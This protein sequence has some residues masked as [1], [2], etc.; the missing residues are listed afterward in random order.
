M[1]IHSLRKLIA[2]TITLAV[3]LA[4][5]FSPLLAN[6]AAASSTPS[7]Q[8]S[9]HQ[10]AGPSA[11]NDAMGA[12]WRI[13]TVDS[14]PDVGSYGSIAFDPRDGS[15]WASYYDATN[16]DLKLAHYLRSTGGN[17][18]PALTWQ[19]TTI[20]GSASSDRGQY[21]S[22]DVY[23]NAAAGVWRLGVSYY[24][25]TTKGLRYYEKF[26]TPAPDGSGWTMY[27][28]EGSNNINDVIGRYSSIK[29]DQTGAANVAYQVKLVS[30]GKNGLKYAHFVGAGNGSCWPNNR[31]Q[32]DEI[33]MA[34]MTYPGYYTSIDVSWSG[35]P[36]IAYYD[37]LTRDLKY[38]YLSSYNGSPSGNCGPVKA[39]GYTWT[40]YTIDSAGDVGKSA[41]YHAS[42]NS[43]HDPAQV[44][45]YDATNGQLKYAFQIGSGGNCG[46]NNTT[47]Q[48]DV[49]DSAIGKYAVAA[50]VGI[51]LAVDPNYQPVIAYVNSDSDLSAL[52]LNLAYPQINGNCGPG[53]LIFTW[54]C[55]TINHGGQYTDEAQYVSLAL[56]PTGNAA[57]AYSET[58]TYDIPNTDTL[59]VAFQEWRLYIPSVTK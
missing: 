52:D 43:L 20:D 14:S 30:T 38:A 54:R 37:A 57:I 32:C 49:I 8:S 22:I 39:N 25:A 47:W 7:I 17:C 51:S 12:P 33:D 42:H 28:I 15:L 2:I 21:S 10:G 50:P 24:D 18:G 44:A 26:E 56:S 45:Y 58:N 55:V 3:A 53:P 27:E 16:T 36:G 13:N 35:I 5:G 4:T 48:C 59:K 46:F 11:L 23:Y 1:N 6:P 19:C 40:C 9:I 34:L 29:F 41:S 31:F